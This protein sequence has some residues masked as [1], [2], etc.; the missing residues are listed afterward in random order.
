M[1]NEHK[2]ALLRVIDQ[3]IA[4]LTEIVTNNKKAGRDI[5]WYEGRLIGLQDARDLLE[6]PLEELLIELNEYE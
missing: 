2:D 6:C 1:T 3:R 5:E 4:C